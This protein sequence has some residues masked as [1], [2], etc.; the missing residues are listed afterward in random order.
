MKISIIEEN[1]KKY[2]FGV[3]LQGRE[4]NL[5]LRKT[6]MIVTGYRLQLG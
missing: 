6:A 2:Y 1:E 5:V 4:L 3:K